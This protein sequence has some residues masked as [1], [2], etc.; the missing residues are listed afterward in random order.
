MNTAIARQEILVITL[1]GLSASPAST[2]WYIDRF[3]SLINY[4]I[5][6]GIPIITMDD[7]YKLQSGPITI[8][9]AN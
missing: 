3:Q 2:D 7:L 5:T 8:P 6:Q 4:C 1:Q 9:V